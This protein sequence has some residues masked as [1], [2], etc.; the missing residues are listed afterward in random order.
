VSFLVYEVLP[1]RQNNYAIL[2]QC[3]LDSAV[4]VR[5]NMDSRAGPV[6]KLASAAQAIHALIV[7]SSSRFMIASPFFSSNLI[8]SFVNFVPPTD[9]A[10]YGLASSLP[11]F[12]IDLAAESFFD[13]AADSGDDRGV[14]F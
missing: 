6:G 8:S 7:L 4:G 14:W 5:V 1:I 12:A 10:T 13:G 3:G 2:E 11:T 9:F